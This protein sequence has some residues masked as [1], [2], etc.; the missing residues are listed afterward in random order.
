MDIGRMERD[1][2]WLDLGVREEGGTKD[3]CQIFDLNKWMG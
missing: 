3:E 2:Y 1:G